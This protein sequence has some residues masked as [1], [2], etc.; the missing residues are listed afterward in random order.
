MSDL[1]QRREMAC[2]FV[3][4][5]P[6]GRIDPS[7]LAGAFDCWNSAMGGLISGATYLKGIAGA[8]A[9]LPDMAMTIE[10]TVAEERQVA[11]RASSTARL[12]DGAIYANV[13]HFLFEFEDLQIRRIHAFMNT[14]LAEETLMPLIW[15]NQKQFS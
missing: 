14:K 2:A 4:Q 5:I 15:G 12:P 6:S 8:A 13:Y 3:R 9:V 10:G 1:E 11:V 7:I